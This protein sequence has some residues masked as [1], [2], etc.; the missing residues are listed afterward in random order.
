MWH[1]DQGRLAYFQ[2]DA[3]RAISQ[4][5]QNHDFKTATQAD[6]AA[7]TGLPFAAPST[8]SPWR[9][10]SRVLKHCLLISENGGVA[11]PTAVSALLAQPGIVTSDEYFHFLAQVSTEPSPALEGWS[12]TAQFRYPLLVAL[13]YLLAKAAVGVNPFATLDEIIG[14]YRLT[15]FDGS[16]DD[17]AFIGALGTAPA[18][19]HSAGQTAPDAMRRQARESL[20]VMC[21]ISYLHLVGDRVFINLDQKDA[22]TAFK[23]LDPMN[24]PRAAD[25]DAE[26]RRL[27][28]LFAGGSTLDFFDYANTVVNE[29][30]ESG[31]EEGNKVQKTHVTIERNSGLRKAFFE[32]NPTT[33]CDVCDVD[34]AKSYPWT[35]RVMDLHHLLPLSSGTRVVGTGTTFEDLVPLCPSCHRAVHR[36]YGDWF[37]TTSRRDF[38]SRDE[39][40]GVYNQMKTKFSGLIHA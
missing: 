22:L 32:A 27:S 24:G 31:F 7:A 10:Y 14:A 30:V 28:A 2:F 39:A 26:I 37:R 40:V 38:N 6:L 1:W 17:S 9:N 16:E 18:A 34:T 21:Q 36:Y 4:F 11:D 29:V 25:R 20:K 23:E 15:G 33:V 13:K 19:Y 8:H 5:V 12:P 35:E 3:L